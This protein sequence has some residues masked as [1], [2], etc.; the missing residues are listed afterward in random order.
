[1]VRNLLLHNCRLT[2]R[3]LIY[4]NNLYLVL[5]LFLHDRRPMHRIAFRVRQTN[6]PTRLLKRAEG[7]GREREA[8]IRNEYVFVASYVENRTPVFEGQSIVTVGAHSIRPTL[9]SIQVKLNIILLG[10]RLQ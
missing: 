7:R 1:M 5:F 10:V 8:R 6:A 3:W 2:V 4:A 9:A